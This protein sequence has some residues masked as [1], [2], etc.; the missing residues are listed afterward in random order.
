MLVLTLHSDTVF[1]LTDTNTGEALGT[2]KR[3]DTSRHK[4]IQIRLGFNFPDHIKI[5]RL[6][7]EEKA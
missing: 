2:I 4:N 5:T 3:S 7:Q 6:K 1:A